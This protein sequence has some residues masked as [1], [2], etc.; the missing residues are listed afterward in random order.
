[1]SLPMIGESTPSKD[2]L[3]CFHRRGRRITSP[4][5]LLP[6]F[7]NLHKALIVISAKASKDL[8]GLLLFPFNGL[9]I[10]QSIY[11]CC[12]MFLIMLRKEA[13]NNLCRFNGVHS[14]KQTRIN[15]DFFDSWHLLR[16]KITNFAVS[17]P[18]F[19]FF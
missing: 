11:L 15:I 2:C 3:A 16:S 12:K 13:Q 14:Q 1:M 10:Q 17:N 9:L 5:C 7:S 19:Q 6:G 18:S 8:V 4:V